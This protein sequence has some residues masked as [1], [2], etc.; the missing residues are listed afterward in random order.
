[1]CFSLLG[2]P[3]LAELLAELECGAVERGDFVVRLD[4]QVGDSERVQRRQQML[5][6]TDRAAAAGQR[7]VVAGIGDVLEAD[8]NCGLVRERREHDSESRRRGMQNDAGLEAGVKPLPAHHDR[9]RDGFLRD[10]AGADCLAA[11]GADFGAHAACVG[12]VGTRGIALER[13]RDRCEQSADREWFLNEVGG[14][15]LGSG[16]RALN[17]GVARDH[18]DRHAGLFGFDPA[19]QFDAVH[20]GH[21]H[22]EQNDRG[23][24]ARDQVHH[25]RS[26]A[27]IDD[28]KAF[29]T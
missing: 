10:S 5:D 23:T 2:E 13:P 1:L 9:A 19:E 20:L 12:R 17:V 8:W 6:G 14:A 7:G 15:E 11:G 26:I 3:C 16:D 21:P 18:Y 28:P 4:E 22:V 25:A 24:L 27:G 29:V